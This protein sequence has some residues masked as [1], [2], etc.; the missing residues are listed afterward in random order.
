M[1]HR[2]LSGTLVLL[3]RWLKVLY[4]IGV[5]FVSIEIYTPPTSSKLGRVVHL[6]ILQQLPSVWYLSKCWLLMLPL[7]KGS[8]K[9]LTVMIIHQLN[10]NHENASIVF[11]FY[12]SPYITRHFLQLFIYFFSTFLDI[13]MAYP[14][15][16]I[17]FLLVITILQL[18][19]S[20]LQSPIY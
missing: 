16:I 9:D 3:P 13:M 19:N 18:P 2:S 6:Q 20:I 8:K 1:N 4:V 7:W 15:M 12:D 14:L 17:L 11:V 5:M 10:K